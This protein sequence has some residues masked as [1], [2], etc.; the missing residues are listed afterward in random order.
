MSSVNI[1]FSF[2]LRVDLKKQQQHERRSSLEDRLPPSKNPGNAKSIA[3][4]IYGG[5]GE[6]FGGGGEIFG[7]GAEIFIN[8]AKVDH[9]SRYVG[10]MVIMLSEYSF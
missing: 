5:G 7:G 10:S 1:L 6:I 9:V 3:G 2:F 4:H 8:V